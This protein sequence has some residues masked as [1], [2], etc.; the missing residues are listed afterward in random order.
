ML[1]LTNY[2]RL[3]L[4]VLSGSFT[5]YGEKRNP[6][7]GIEKMIILKDVCLGD[8]RLAEELWV[9]IP[10]WVKKPCF[11]EG[12]KVFFPSRVTIRQKGSYEERVWKPTELVLSF[13]AIYKIGK[14][15]NCVRN[16]RL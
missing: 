14:T 13:S 3:N 2:T 16:G 12:D 9:K 1:E 11:T 7:G 4:W 8:T 10:Q 15:R 5:G 6:N